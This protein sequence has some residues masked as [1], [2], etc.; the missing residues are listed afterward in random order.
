MEWT[1]VVVYE[2]G[3]H[4]ARTDSIDAIIGILTEPE[5]EVDSAYVFTGALPLGEFL[6]GAVQY[7]SLDPVDD[8]DKIQKIREIIDKQE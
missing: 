2:D 7:G 3:R 5:C 1:V 6:R 8:L 4:F